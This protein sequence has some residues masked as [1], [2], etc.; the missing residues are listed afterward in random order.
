M[1]YGFV[2]DVHIDNFTY[3]K[4]K[5]IAGVNDRARLTL[6]A[7]ERACGECDVLFVLG[8][9]FH[10][11]NPSPQLV[12][13]TM[14]VFSNAMALG[15]LKEVHL[16]L[17]NHDAISDI[18]GDNALAT[19]RFLRDVYVHD[20][21]ES[22]TAEGGLEVLAVPYPHVPI[23]ISVS[24]VDVVLMHHGIVDKSTPEFLKESGIY[25]KDLYR[26][27][28]ENDVSWLFA[29][30]WHPHKAWVKGRVAQ[31]G[32]LAPASFSDAGIDDKGT[33]II[34]E[35][36]PGP[37]DLLDSSFDDGLKYSVINIPGPRFLQVQTKKA[38][39]DMAAS[40]KAKGHTPFISF[41]MSEDDGQPLPDDG[42]YIKAEASRGQIEA[43]ASTKEEIEQ[44][45]ATTKATEVLE[46][47]LKFR[48][49]MKWSRM[50]DTL[51]KYMGA[52]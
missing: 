21:V 36:K 38:A 46:K 17:G 9:L 22:F 13:A 31:V 32:C 1:K 33:M 39:L 11:A 15:G 7:L 42:V 20:R 41:P 43:N 34:L 12:A 3:G 47:F 49:P 14:D 40:L 24:G 16:L 37:L 10:H 18:R 45:L 6:D 4:G 52:S 8:D 26:W 23:G 44:I 2:A 5:S 35:S 51:V 28:E 19:F 25:W 29:G 50:L 27:C 30:D 48:Y